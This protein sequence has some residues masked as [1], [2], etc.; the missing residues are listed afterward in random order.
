MNARVDQLLDQALGLPSDERSAL[1]VALLDSL[2]GS[3]DVAISDA[4]QQEIKV[5]KA[6][7]R[8]GAVTA[9][10]WSEVRARLGTL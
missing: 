5:R 7:L 6:Q 4:W 2:D 1:V 9:I 8:S 3:D 10:P